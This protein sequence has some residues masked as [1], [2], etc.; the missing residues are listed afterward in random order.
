M[1]RTAQRGQRP[2]R[3]A[4]P[5][6]REGAPFERSPASPEGSLLESIASGELDPAPARD[7]SSDRR[8]AAPAAHHGVDRRARRPH[9][10]RSR[11]RQP[12]RATALPSGPSCD[13]HRRRRADRDDQPSAAG[14]AVHQRDDPLP[15]TGASIGSVSPRGHLAPAETS[16]P[17]PAR[18]LLVFHAPSRSPRSR[19]PAP[20]FALGSAKDLELPLGFPRSRARRGEPADRR[21]DACAATDAGAPSPRPPRERVGHAEARARGTPA[22]SGLE[23]VVTSSH[24]LWVK[25]PD[26]CL[27]IAASLARRSAALVQSLS[28]I[29]QRS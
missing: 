6:A 16:A 27:T 24:A 11:A 20:A 18:A 2:R 21:E 12:P 9:R 15:A 13:R 26:P 29:A 19:S 10:W 4:L 5:P 22:S 28:R 1:S 7:R 23:H 14:R 17:A 3:V 8:S 25:T